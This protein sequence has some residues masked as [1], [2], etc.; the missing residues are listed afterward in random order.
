MPG[1]WADAGGLHHAAA[2]AASAQGTPGAATVLAAPP[3]GNSSA[4]PDGGEPSGALD[5]D[6]LVAVGAAL[7]LS[8]A[9]VAVAIC[10][11]PQGRTLRARMAQPSLWW[12]L[13]PTVVQVSAFCLIG[14]VLLAVGETATLPHPPSTCSR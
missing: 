1:G 13:P 10:Y 9:A 6:V 12:L 8:W 7:A 11:G 5:P 4:T 3:A 14:P 2:A